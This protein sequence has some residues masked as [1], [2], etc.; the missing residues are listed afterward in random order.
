MQ[1]VLYLLV[2]SDL[3][4]C[5]KDSLQTFIV[6]L[7]TVCPAMFFC[8]LCIAYCSANKSPIIISLLNHYCLLRIYV[9][10]WEGKMSFLTKSMLIVILG[11]SVFQTLD[12]LGTD[13]GHNI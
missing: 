11:G 7:L 1:K 10:V 4:Y 12:L 3:I 8:H 2:A 13:Q 9:N 5:L 6:P